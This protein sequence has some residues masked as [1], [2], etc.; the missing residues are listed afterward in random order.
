MPI[1]LRILFYL[2]LFAFS[3]AGKAVTVD[4]SGWS[5]GEAYYQGNDQFHGTF[6]FALKPT[7]QVIDGLTVS[8]RLDAVHRQKS[9]EFFKKSHWLNSDPEPQGGLFL[10]HSEKSFKTDWS[11]FQHNVFLSQFYIT[12]QG[13]F[14]RFQLGKAP[15]HFGMG[16]TYS[17]DNPSFANWVSHVTWLSLYLKYSR[18]YLQPAVVVREEQRLA[19]LLTGGV[20]GERWKV[21][22][23]YRHEKFHRAE[24]FGQY[25]EDFWDTKLSVSYGFTKEHLAAALEAGVNLWFLLKPRVEL[26]TGYASK[27]FSFHPNYNVGLFLWNYLISGPS[28]FKGEEGSAEEDKSSSSPL[29]IE[30]GCINDVIYFSPRL[31]FSF[32][33]ETVKVAP[34][35]VA[36]WLVSEER[37]DYELN[38]EMK[39][40][41][42]SFLTLKAQGGVFYKKKKMN[43]GFLTQAAVEF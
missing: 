38:L 14:A 6:Y 36:G 43:F 13:E 12:W 40:N 10:L 1:S 37:F 18:F 34:Q 11:L 35:F 39:Y 15:Y 33:E 16:L 21:E 19:P 8:A 4:W 22:G 5:R 26:K 7:V 3:F 28:C 23:L 27:N 31:V 25:E 17:V 24:L 42:E 30:E 20:S 41:L 2:V 29:W 32:W 9:D